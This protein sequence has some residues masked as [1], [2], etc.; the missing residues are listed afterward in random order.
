MASKTKPEHYIDNKKFSLAVMEYVKEC[1]RKNELN[2]ESPQIPRYIGECFI[3]ISRRLSSAGNFSGY[4]WK[5]EMVSDGIENCVTAIKNYNIDAP[6]RTG[7]PN[8]FGYFSKIVFW[9][10]LRRIAAEKKQIEIRERVIANCSHE[11]FIN[12]E[13]DGSA[14]FVEMMKHRHFDYCENSNH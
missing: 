8:A 2:E 11:S 10:F 3:R 12:A 7:V 13:D 6:T 1:R 4:S 5:E 9:A 14:G